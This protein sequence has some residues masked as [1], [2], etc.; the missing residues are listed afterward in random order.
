M[1]GK[2]GQ[3]T[4]EQLE[5]LNTHIERYNP[6]ATVMDG[7]LAIHV[8]D[9]HAIKDKRVLIVEDGP[10]ITHGGTRFGAGYLAATQGGA[11]IVDP[12][13][14][15]V[16]EIA[17]AYERYPHIGDVLPA[18]GY[19]EVQL[20]D[21]QKTIGRAPCDIVMV[22]TPIDLSGLI[23]IDQ[24]TVRVTYSFEERGAPRLQGL[25]RDALADTPRDAPCA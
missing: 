22:A 6:H 11:Q 20:D 13:P 10:T 8:D 4:A 1:I 12:R 18:L 3:A 23:Q 16:G 25:L 15:A 24:P 17:Q 7:Q 2:V 14:Y 9:A 5:I 21:L 19:A